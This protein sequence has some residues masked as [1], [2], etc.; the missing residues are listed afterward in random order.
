MAQ[1]KVTET[2]KAS[3][4]GIRIEEFQAGET[5]EMGDVLAAMFVRNGWGVDVDAP[6]KPAR[7]K[8]SPGPKKR[9]G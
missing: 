3:P 9:K 6:V 1:I 7:T 8:S 4:D 2:R 5:V